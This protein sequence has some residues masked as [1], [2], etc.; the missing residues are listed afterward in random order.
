MTQAW[1]VYL[2]ECAD[3]SYYC[4]I[5]T[6]PARRLAQHN[7]ERPGGARCTRA[8]RPVKL[9]LTVPCADQGSA[10]RLENAIKLLPRSRKFAALAACQSGDAAADL[11]PGGLPDALA[12]RNGD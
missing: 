8:R 4:G 3:G 12:A 10:L 1:Q 5:T 6:D 2:L 11:L 7:G 9:L